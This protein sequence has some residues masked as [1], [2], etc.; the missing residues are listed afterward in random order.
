MPSATALKLKFLLRLKIHFFPALNSICILTGRGLKPPAF[1]IGLVWFEFPTTAFL[2]PHYMGCQ[3]AEEA[4]CSSFKERPQDPQQRG[5]GISVIVCCI[6]WIWNPA[7]VVSR[8]SEK[9]VIDF[10]KNSVY[11]WAY[12]PRPSNKISSNQLNKRASHLFLRNNQC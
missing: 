10:Y 11:S 12:N 8:S 5:V 2:R 1:H 9:P 7:S 4:L 6:R 3:E